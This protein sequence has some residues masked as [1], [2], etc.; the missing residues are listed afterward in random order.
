[1]PKE[2]K[3][4]AMCPSLEGTIAWLRKSILGKAL[5]DERL[6]VPPQDKPELSQP[7]R[8]RQ[9]AWCLW[10]VRRL[11]VWW[12]HLFCLSKSFCFSPFM[13]SSERALGPALHPP[14]MLLPHQRH[15]PWT[16]PVKARVTKQVR[17]VQQHGQ[18]LMQWKSVSSCQAKG[19]HS[20][21]YREGF[22]FKIWCCVS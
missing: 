20:P 18:H 7:N 2:R 9:D 12:A 3:K 16:E 15:P 1:V 4:G 10:C 19:V 14:W 5:T 17:C 11:F 13:R 6:I 22:V 21:H 8:I